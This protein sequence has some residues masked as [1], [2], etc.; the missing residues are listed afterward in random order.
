MYYMGMNSLTF[1]QRSSLPYEILLYLNGWYFGLF[2][3]CECLLY[4]F[5]GKCDQ[6]NPIHAQ[7]DC[8]ISDNDERSS[9]LPIFII[10]SK[11]YF[12][13]IQ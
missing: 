11:T 13:D 7:L 3:V 2:F 4:A 6:K 5:K 10:L 9:K 12:M 1:I 8:I